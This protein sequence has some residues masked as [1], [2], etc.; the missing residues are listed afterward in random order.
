MAVRGRRVPSNLLRP[1][2]SWLCE[3]SMET[4]T[5]P[6]KGMLVERLRGLL[7]LALKSGDAPPQ[8]Y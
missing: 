6:P 2:L 5:S 8:G 3:G 1:Q 4:H 7:R